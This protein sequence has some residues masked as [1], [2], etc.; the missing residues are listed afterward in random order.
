MGSRMIKV[1]LLLPHSSGSVIAELHRVAG[2]LTREDRADGVLINAK[3][4]SE[5]AA[6]YSRYAID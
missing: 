4:T 1:T 6:R 3:M 5:Q 2:D